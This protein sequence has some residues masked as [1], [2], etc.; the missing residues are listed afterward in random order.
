M[1]Y[2]TQLEAAESHLAKNDP[3]LAAV[4]KKYGPCSLTTHSDHYAELVSS[5][6]GQQLSTKAGNTI[7]RRVL[8]VFDGKM[9][10]P[11]QLI[12]VDTERLRACGVSYAKVGYMKDL[13]THIID[14]RLNMPHIS[15]LPNDEIIRELTAVKG[16]GQWSAHMFMIFSLGRLDILPVGDLG[17]RKG[18][19]MLYGLKDLPNGKT[20]EKLAFDN[21]WS[22]YESVAAWYL[23]QS[24]DNAPSQKRHD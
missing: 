22:P 9:P 11:E 19:M 2:S 4:I 7:W 8:D 13:A 16:I 10:T 20:L 23:W 5:I 12:K 24:L 6:V 14:G 3:Q 18:A 21:S 15:K 17:V 1:N